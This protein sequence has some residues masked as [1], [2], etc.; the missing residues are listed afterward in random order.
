[1]WWMPHPWRHSRSGW[2]GL[3]A[4]RS[5]C[6]CPCSVQGSWIRWPL[7][8]TPTQM[9]LRFHAQH[10]WW[11]VTDGLPRNSRH[12][13]GE[14]HLDFVRK[15]KEKQD[16]RGAVAQCKT[17]EGICRGTG[18]RRNGKWYLR[19]WPHPVPD[20]CSLSYFSLNPF[21]TIFQCIPT[22][23]SSYSSA[24]Y[25]RDQQKW[26]WCSACNQTRAGYTRP[27]CLPL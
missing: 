2:R 19:D 12:S 23:W 3:W 21:S 25:W 5:S 20:H 24:S 11:R 7:K 15:E 8:S 13:F 6:R 10:R 4:T 27:W 17:N 9:V 26:I 1:M 18:L 14:C 16:L 22:V